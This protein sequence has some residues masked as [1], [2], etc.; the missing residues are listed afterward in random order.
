MPYKD[1]REYLSVLDSKGLLKR[2]GVEVDKDWELAAIVRNAFQAIPERDRPVLF[3]EKVK[4]YSIPVVGGLLGA[5]R[6]VHAL[7]LETTIEGVAAK[8]SKA[9]ASP[10]PP[11]RVETGPVKENILK[12]DAID[13]PGFIPAPTWTAGI[14]PAPYLTAPFVITRDPETGIVNVGTYRMQVKGKKRLGLNIFVGH[15]G[16]THVA[17]NDRQNRPT[18]VA[19]VL[20]ADPAVGLVSVSR[21]PYGVD[22]LAVAGGLRGEP[23]EVVRCETCDLEVPATAEMVI[24]GE[25]IPNYLEPEG[26]F[27]EFSGYVG[28]GGPA[29]VVEVKC[30]TYRNHPIHQVFFSQAPPSESSCMRT[31]AWEASMYKRLVQDLKLPVTGV[32]LPESGGTL[33]WVVIAMTK[34]DSFQVRQA[35]WGAWSIDPTAGK[36][37]VVVDDDIDIRDAFAVNWAIAFRVQP[38]RDVW[39]QEKTPAQPADPSVRPD[40]VDPLDP[41]KS[42]GSKLCIDATRKKEF[43]PAAMPPAEHLAI[44]RERWKE[45]GF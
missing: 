22:E 42:W 15:H 11:R 44:V 7:A 38:D 8:W 23:L 13:I 12:G 31:F 30:I 3:F 40:Q 16:A 17:A 6:K 1:L 24:E 5:S 45:Y 27:G 41:N 33:E 34:P 37:T 18:P 26:P 39:V 43:P 36:I 9:L 2:I 21:V 35:M 19:I 32:H 4:G 14:D 10:L 29:S 25:V 20:G 28:H